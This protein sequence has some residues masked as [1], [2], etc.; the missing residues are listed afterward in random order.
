M[1]LRVV[2]L[3]SF[4]MTDGRTS[5]MDYKGP[6]DPQ[7][8][9][10]LHTVPSEIVPKF[11]WMDTTWGTVRSVLALQQACRLWHSILGKDRKK[12]MVS[13]WVQDGKGFDENVKLREALQ[14][15]PICINNIASMV[16]SGWYMDEEIANARRILQTSSPELYLLAGADVNNTDECGRTALIAA[17]G[18]YGANEDL[19]AYLPTLIKAEAIPDNATNSTVAQKTNI[20]HQDDMGNTAL[21]YASMNG[22][23][24]YVEVLLQHG[25][26]KEL[27]NHD[28]RTPIECREWSFKPGIYSD[29]VERIRVLL[30]GDMSPEK[31]IASPIIE[32]IKPNATD[33][34]DALLDDDSTWPINEDFFG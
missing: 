3:L 33:A 15:M 11:L 22:A 9:S 29:R 13:G 21:P 24:R 19:V 26:D 16:R 1:K 7:V 25:A 18:V 28:N 34:L 30:R 20:N 8:D 23:L 4:L 6:I 12:K 2:L 31:S 27:K 17:M 32:E 10:I 14:S 5:A